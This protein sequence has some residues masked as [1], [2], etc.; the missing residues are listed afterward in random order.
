MV[1]AELVAKMKNTVH[2][3]ENALAEMDIPPWEEDAFKFA[4]I[5]RTNSM[6][7]VS[8]NLTAWLV[9][10]EDVL[11]AQLSPGQ[12]LIGLDVFASKGILLTVLNVSQA[13]LNALKEWKEST[14]NASVKMAS[15]LKQEFARP[16]QSA[17]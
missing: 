10:I 8:V 9:L 7:A 13:C 11:L 15:T 6:T 4:P 2:S 17:P 3:T 5:W 16:L 14:E 1:P 12:P